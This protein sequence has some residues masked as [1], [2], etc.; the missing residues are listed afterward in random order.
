M[1]RGPSFF[2]CVAC[3]AIGLALISIALGLLYRDTALI[4]EAIVK[5]AIEEKTSYES[6]DEDDVFAAWSPGYWLGALASGTLGVMLLGGAVA[7]FLYDL[8][9]LIQA[10]RRVSGARPEDP[11][12]PA[13]G[14]HP[15]DP[16]R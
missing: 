4:Q 14:S 8:P 9:G 3:V 7:I 13:W 5:L 11:L 10:S 15:G 6:L 12:N 16:P 2:A 1:K